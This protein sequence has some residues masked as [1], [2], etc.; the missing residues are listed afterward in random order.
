VSATV[1]RIPVFFSTSPDPFERC[2]DRV[3][4]LPPK[5]WII[6]RKKV[7]Q[8][9]WP[10][11][12]LVMRD[13]TQGYRLRQ[14]SASLWRDLA[15][16]SGASTGAPAI[17]FAFARAY[18]VRKSELSPATSPPRVDRSGPLINPT[19]LN[20][21]KGKRAATPRLRKVCYWLETANRS[22][23]MGLSRRSPNKVKP[24]P[25]G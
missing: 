20:T 24:R 21:L 13:E 15:Q 6:A 22:C 3:L 7:W 8:S 10:Q 9:R 14:D 12:D 25:L 17:T 19:K 23:I 1:N 11:H 16:G 4:A 2:P 18:R 5:Q